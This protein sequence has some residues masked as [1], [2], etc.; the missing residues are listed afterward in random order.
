MKISEEVR[1]YAKEKGLDSE[2]DAIADGM[3]KKAE[4]FNTSGGELYSS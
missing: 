2:Q 3:K 4:E 1:Q